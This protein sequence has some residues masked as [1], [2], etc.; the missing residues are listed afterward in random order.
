MI[1]VVS[2]LPY[3]LKAVEGD[4]CVWNLLRTSTI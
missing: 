3:I 1:Y 4:T 2:T